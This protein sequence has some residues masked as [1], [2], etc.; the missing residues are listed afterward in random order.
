MFNGPFVLAQVLTWASTWG[1]DVVKGHDGLRAHLDRPTIPDLAMDAKGALEE[2]RGFPLQQD[3]LVIGEA[4]EGRGDVVRPTVSQHVAGFDVAWQTVLPCETGQEGGE[5]SMF[6]NLS[7]R[8][9][10][11]FFVQLIAEGEGWWIRKEITVRGATW[12]TANRYNLREAGAPENPL[13][14]K[15]DAIVVDLRQG[16]VGEPAL[17]VRQGTPIDVILGMRSETAGCRRE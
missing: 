10:L 9:P 2:A 16:V 11:A 4:H 5:R 6:T 15:R 3:A 14:L 17:E 1:S 12:A 8:R 7:G 13:P